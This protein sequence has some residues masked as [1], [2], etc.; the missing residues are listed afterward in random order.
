MI[1][2]GSALELGEKDRR[3]GEKKRW[4]EGRKVEAMGL[5]SLSHSP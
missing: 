4:N 1:K 3:D 5:S 2:I